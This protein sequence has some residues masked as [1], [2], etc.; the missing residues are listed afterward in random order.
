[1]WYIENMWNTIDT[2][3]NSFD[4]IKYSKCF[5]KDDTQRTIMKYGTKRICGTSRKYGT[6]RTCGTV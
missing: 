4:D 1:M 5:K 6:L 2:N 3:S